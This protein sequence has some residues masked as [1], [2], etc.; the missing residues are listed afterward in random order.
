[1]SDVPASGERTTVETARMGHPLLSL[2]LAAMM[3]DVQ[4]HS[5]AVY[6]LAHD[7]PVLEMAVMAG[8]PRSF[9]APWERVSLSAP[10]PVSEAVRE[11]RLVWVNGEEQMARRYPRI[12]VVLPYPFATAALPVATRDTTYGAVF[13]TW[14]GSHPPELSDRERDKLTSACDRLAIRLRRA[15]EEGR[16]V[17]P[18]PDLSAPS[19]TTVAGTL[20]TVEAARMVARLP[21]GMCSLDLHGR[22]TF[23]NAATAEL[24]GIPV[25]ALLGMQLWA[26]VP[27][28][29]DPAH[30]DRYRAALMSQQVTSFT[31][32]KPPHEWLSFRLY[33]GTNGLSVRISRA[34]SA[35]SPK[36]G[37]RQ[38]GEDDGPGRLV[39]IDHVLAMA[40]AL[41][42]AVGVQDVVELVANEIVPAVGSQALVVLGSRAGRLHVLGHH[43]YPDPHLV[44]QFDGMPLSAQTPGARALTSGVPAFFETRQQLEHLYPVRR[45]TPDGMGAWAY[46]PLIAQGQPVGT[47]VLG[48][49]DPHPFPAEER[50][51]LTSLSGLIAQ[52]L[53]RALLYDAKHQLAHGLQAALLPHSLPSIPGIDAA[54][55][56]L[57]ATRGMDIGGDFFDLVLS[58]GRASAVIGDVQG[59][60]V[61]A[62]GMMGQIR[63]AVRAYTTVGQA[64]ED[65][66]SSTNRL[67]IDLGSDLFASCLYLRLDPAHGTAVMARAGHPPPLLRRPD[68]RVKVLD[69]AGGPLLGIDASATYPTTEVALAEGSVLALYTDGLIEAPGVDIEDA[70]AD[71]GER[72]ATTGNRP[73]EDLADR[74]VRETGTAEERSDD[75]A[76]LLLRA[77]PIG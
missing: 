58:H 1:M 57:P 63:T 54:S 37:G 47:C 66:M 5:G 75:V 15:E 8:L 42:E 53:Q 31:A 41:T 49:A 46:L 69:L 71:L 30:E 17:L 62:A 39:T 77:V 6:L 34:R 45:T 50:A 35:A 16:P 52:A 60:N 38:E 44:E 32:L 64:P 33:P 74:L 68:G 3:D 72:L 24:L 19:T 9:A 36:G 2:A 20:G 40:S 48:Y 61:T 27:W 26:S 67:L 43:G 13:L 14:P 56:Y 55:R 4:A 10:A 18:E 70:L 59:H 21:Y 22:I 51:V 29:N 25:S 28:L 12:A 23:A 76:L 11:R 73:L 7:A 65:V